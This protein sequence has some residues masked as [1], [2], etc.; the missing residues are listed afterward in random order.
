MLEMV[1]MVG[2][3]GFLVL[4][5]LQICRKISVYFDG[6][7]WSGS[8]CIR[9]TILHDLLVSSCRKNCKTGQLLYASYGNSLQMTT[10]GLFAH[11]TIDVSG[12]VLFWFGVKKYV[13]LQDCY[14]EMMCAFVCWFFFCVFFFVLDFIN[15]KGVL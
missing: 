8:L 11:L 3:F 5:G 10:L 1:L 15:T 2:L 13:L 14:F 6:L 7:K 12:I 4:T 9:S